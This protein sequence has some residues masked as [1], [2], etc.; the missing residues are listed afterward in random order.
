LGLHEPPLISRAYSLDNP[1]EIKEN[2]VLAVETY[3]GP[4]GGKH[5]VR[6]EEML[7]VTDTGHEVISQYP[8]QELHEC[9]LI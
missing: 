6:I 5:G 4:K 1:W 9:P 8:I 7:V 3:A 2:M